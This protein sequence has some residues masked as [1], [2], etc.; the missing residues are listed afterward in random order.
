ME[1]H[2]KE[3]LLIPSIFPE[4]NNFM[5]FNLKKS[6]INKISISEQDKKDYGI[7]EKPEEKRIEWNVQK[8]METPL[9]VDFTKEELDYMRKS[10][11]AIAEQNLPDEVWAV[12]ERIYNESQN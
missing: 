8:D 10:C 5:D 1:L 3:R 2:I 6:I 7:V 11:E 4:R 12:A 9:V